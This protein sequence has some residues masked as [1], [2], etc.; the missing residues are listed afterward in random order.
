MTSL[1]KNEFLN[2]NNFLNFSDTFYGA[3]IQHEDLHKFDKNNYRVL[4]DENGSCLI[5]NKS[6]KLKE[7]DIIFCH[8]MLIEPLFNHLKTVKQFKNIKLITHQSD[9]SIEKSDFDK[10]PNCISKWYAINVNYNHDDLVPIPIGIGND[11]NQKTLTSINFSESIKDNERI[12]KLYL[13]FNLN[14]NYKHRYK[15][16]KVFYDTE[17]SI[18]EKPHQNLQGFRNNLGKYKFSLAPWGN[19][20]D[21]HRLWEALY[22]GSIPVTLAHPS[23]KSFQD[24]P[25]ILLDSYKEFNISEKKFEDFKY[26][27]NEKL[28]INWWFKQ[29]KNSQL[30]SNNN[31][32]EFNENKEV[33]DYNVGLFFKQYH[34]NNKI[35]NRNTIKRKIHKKT[36]GNKLNKTFGV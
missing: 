1:N 32:I 27:F 31:Y 29:I 20:F 30:D 25:I 24:F 21:T 11:S 7:N 17:W 12:N 3:Y 33:H 14:T 28:N 19:G 15:A 23:L 18:L 9:A 16:L 22:A 8:S 13:N 2:S 6:F 26:F 10:K 35:K 4:L 34:Q 5:K 36:F